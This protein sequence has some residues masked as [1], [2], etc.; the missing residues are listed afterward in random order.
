MCR[1]QPHY[2]KARFSRS[3]LLDTSQCCFQLDWPVK[4]S[5]TDPKQLICYFKHKLGYLVLLLKRTS[6]D[7][8]LYNE[9]FNI[10]IYA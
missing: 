8:K 7:L 4:V 1:S 5:K 3:K 6:S 2:P 9:T 10:T